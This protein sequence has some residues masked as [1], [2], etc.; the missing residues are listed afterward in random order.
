M[1]VDRRR[2]DG[3]DRARTRTSGAR[4]TGSTP[5]RT[6]WRSAAAPR[7]SRSTGPWPGCGRARPRAA[8]RL[9]LDLL[10]VDVHALLF[11]GELRGQRLE[12]LALGALERRGLGQLR[13][14][15]QLVAAVEVLADDLGLVVRPL[16]G[17][18]LLGE[19]H[20]LHGVVAAEGGDGQHDG[21]DGGDEGDA[22]AERLVAPLLQ[23]LG[24]RELDLSHA[25]GSG[26]CASPPASRPCRPRRR[27]MRRCVCSSN[28]SRLLSSHS[29]ARPWASVATSCARRANSPPCSARSSRVSRPGAGRQQQRGRRPDHA[30]PGRTS[31]GSPPRRSAQLP[32]S[33]PCPRR[34]R[35]TNTSTPRRRPAA[36]P[37]IWPARVRPASPI[38]TRPRPSATVC[39]RSVTSPTRSTSRRRLARE[40]RASPRSARG[41]GRSAGAAPARRSRARRRSGAASGAAPGSAA[42]RATVSGDGA[43]DKDELGPRLHG[44]EL[45][46]Q[47]PPKI[48]KSV[49]FAALSRRQLSH[50]GPGPLRGAAP[51]PR[52]GRAR[53][54]RGADPAPAQGRQ[55][56]G[57]RAAGAPAR[58]GLLPRDRPLRRPPEP[59][60]RHGGPEGPRRRRRHR[61]GPHPRPPGLRLRAGLH[62]LR[63]LAVGGLR[64]EDLQGDG[65]GHEDGRAGHRPQRLRRRPHPGGRRLAGRLRRHL[66]A[67][68][69]GLGRRPPD[70]GH[71]GAVRGR[72]RLLAGHHRLR[73]HGQ[74]H[75]RTCS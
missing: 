3:Q 34:S 6:R 55:E 51:A 15:H 56:D 4:S 42:T 38:T 20:L 61:L 44:A 11:V 22:T 59:R 36:S 54:R 17:G 45:S 7:R 26:P 24:V 13:L 72:R 62:R 23:L 39:T 33:S 19:Q 49:D 69:A 5:R 21:V 29:P 65:P 71:H 64:A 41:P 2:R 75:R 1:T 63:R 60:L 9:G 43:D 74:E 14:Q 10:L 27:V 66:P 73:L 8:L 46:P 28:S 25:A 57:A 35:C 31:P 32:S 40:R 50:V 48:N 58:P 12:L 30:R 68:H 53:R 37:M 47:T 18:F 67:Q 16:V 52:A 70:L